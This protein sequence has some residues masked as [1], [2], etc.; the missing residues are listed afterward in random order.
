MVGGVVN[1]YI[2]DGRG[3]CGGCN[4]TPIRGGN[5]AGKV[6]GLNIGFAAVCCC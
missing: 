3:C 2:E 6:G 5:W 4:G 1:P